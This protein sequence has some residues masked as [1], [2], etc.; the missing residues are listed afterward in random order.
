[1]AIAHEGL[2]NDTVGKPESELDGRGKMPIFCLRKEKPPK[3]GAFT[4]LLPGRT[5]GLAHQPVNRGL[6]NNFLHDDR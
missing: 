3:L 5:G 1:M 4:R 6:W 2:S